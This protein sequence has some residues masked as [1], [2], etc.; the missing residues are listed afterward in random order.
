MSARDPTKFYQDFIAVK[1]L[2][3]RWQLRIVITVIARAAIFPAAAFGQSQPTLTESEF[4]PE[5]DA[6]LQ[7]PSHESLQHSRE[8]ESP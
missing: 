6:H 7:L 5:V 8:S 4:W 2:S 3:L 1:R